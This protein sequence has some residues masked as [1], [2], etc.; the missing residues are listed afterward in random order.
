M[1]VSLTVYLIAHFYRVCRDQYLLIDVWQKERDR[2]KERH[3]LK[4]LSKN[5][6]A[7]FHLNSKRDLS[8]GVLYV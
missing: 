1:T 3:I 5:V 8:N 2:E 7:F 4:C 6:P